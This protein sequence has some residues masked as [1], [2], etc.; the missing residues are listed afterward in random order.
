MLN[1]IKISHD[2]VNNGVWRKLFRSEL[3]IANTNSEKFKQAIIDLGSSPVTE[4]ALIRI[5]AKTILLG[6]RNVK[7]PQSSELA[8]T[9]ELAIVALTS[10]DDVRTFVDKVSTD[11]QYYCE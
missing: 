1:N 4:E 10:S 5:M 9:E 2:K 8:Y 11:L 3:L 7:D 6:W